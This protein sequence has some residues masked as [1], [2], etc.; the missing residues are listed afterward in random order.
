MSSGFSPTQLLESFAHTRLPAFA[1]TLLPHRAPPE[2]GQSCVVALECPRTAALCFDRVWSIPVDEI[3]C[4]QDIAFNGASDAEAVAALWLHGWRNAETHLRTLRGVD[5]DA[6]AEAIVQGNLDAIVARHDLAV[7]YSMLLLGSALAGE[8]ELLKKPLHGMTR[9]LCTDLQKTVSQVVPLYASE[10]ARDAEYTA[11]DRAVIVTA[12]RQLEVVDENELSWE[13]V[14]EFRR[15]RSSRTD[16]RRLVHWLDAEM[17]GRSA[18]YVIDE[19][20]VRLDKYKRALEKHGL[21]RRLGALTAILD[22]KALASA[23]AAAGGALLAEHPLAAA[24]AAGGVLLGKVLV[25]VGQSEL[26][27]HDVR[28]EHA[29]I[30][31]VAQVSER[32]TQE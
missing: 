24:V 15:D 25:S 12:L 32:L 26:D 18:Q 3:D 9:T 1:R 14:Q 30:A 19:I 21:K 16:Y 4:P 10:A 28:A 6:L 2:P 5:L 22:P 31:F 27:L 13:Q 11:G 7:A 29:D 20:G 8:L 17:A 23:G